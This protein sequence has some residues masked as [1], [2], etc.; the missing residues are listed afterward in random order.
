MIWLARRL[1]AVFT[2]LCVF[3][4][5][6]LVGLGVDHASVRRW[7][8]QHMAPT[9]QEGGDNCF[10]VACVGGDLPLLRQLWLYV[11]VH[12]VVA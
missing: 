5:K 4:S 10:D 3:G 11:H 9:Q 8:Q 1:V 7:Q 2:L 12:S 6:C